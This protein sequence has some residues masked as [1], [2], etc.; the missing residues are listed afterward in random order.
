MERIVELNRGPFVARPAELG[1]VTNVDGALVLDVRPVADFASGH[2]PGALNVPVSGSSFATKAAFVLLPDDRVVLHGAS[3][4]E[5]REAARGL[6]AVGFLDLAGYLE[7]PPLSERVDPVDLDELERLLAEGSVE[8]VD[9]REKDERDEGYIAGSRHIPYR[10]LRA[11]RPPF[12]EGA[13][14]VTIC[15]SGPRAAIA[16]SVLLAAGI[17]ARPVVRGGVE[18]WEDRGGQTVEFRRCGT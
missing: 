9:V 3:E 11:C 8:L 13:Q 14:V 2:V 12:E 6:R 17:S 5:V 1:P 18:D 10:L 15:G 16:A 4:D 7:D